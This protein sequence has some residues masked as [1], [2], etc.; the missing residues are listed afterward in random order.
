MQRMNST[1]FSTAKAAAAASAISLRPSLSEFKRRE[2]V[3]DLLDH[4]ADEALAL[5]PFQLLLEAGDVLLGVGQMRSEFGEA[6]AKLAVGRRPG[7]DHLGGERA[8]LG[9]GRLDRGLSL[10]EAR[11]EAA[12]VGAKGDIDV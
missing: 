5:G 2:E 3:F 7:L 8:H 4:A 12:D 9:G 11:L 1:T 6:R 10:R